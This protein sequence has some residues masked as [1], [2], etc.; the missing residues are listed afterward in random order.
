MGKVELTEKDNG[1]R[2]QLEVG[3]D[4][5]LR[6]EAIPGAGYIWSVTVDIGRILSPVGE[7]VFERRD[8]GLMGGVEYQVFTYKV[9]SAGTLPLRYEYRRPWEKQK[10]PEREF[11]VTLVA[12]E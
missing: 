3:E 5:V 6:L 12:G 11:T 1:S 7:P 8:P 2:V 9:I 4:L 10:P